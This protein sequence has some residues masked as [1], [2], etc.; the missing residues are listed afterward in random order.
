MRLNK[1]IAS[2]TKN[3]RR[4]A[5]ELIKNGK[6]LVN[7]RPAVLGQQ[8]EEED[9]VTVR[10]KN[11]DQVA[12][13]LYYLVHKP[14]GYVSTTKDPEGRRTVMELVP[15]DERLYPVGRLDYDSEGLILLTNDGQLT[16]RLTHPKF[17][18]EK[19]YKVLVKG[20][21]TKQSI[22]KLE[23]GVFIDGQRTSPAQVNIIE[24][25]DGKTWLSMTIHEGRNRQIR[26]MCHVVGHPVVRLI[27]LKLGPY[28]LGDL[29]PGQSKI[30]ENLL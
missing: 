24:K 9:I 4:S 27:R 3:S 17:Q 11:L 25:Q 5:D 26:K 13:P 15:T 8:V 29:K 28:E 16:N 30:V 1:Y 19:L 10:G 7:G 12:K 18:T 22:S 14:T 6:V 21:P 20:L 2:H 23:A